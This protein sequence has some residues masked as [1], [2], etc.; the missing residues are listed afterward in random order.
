[1]Q[2]SK[3]TANSRTTRSATVAHKREALAAFIDLA[4]LCWL[5]ALREEQERAGDD[6]GLP[7]PH[8]D[9]GVRCSRM[10]AE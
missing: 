4:L 5:S 6:A 7:L 9:G 3:Q 2:S 8:Q 10:A 1:M